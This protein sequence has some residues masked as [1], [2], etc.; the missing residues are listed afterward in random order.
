MGNLLP[1][2]VRITPQRTDTPPNNVSPTFRPNVK[3]RLP[4]TASLL[5]QTDKENLLVQCLSIIRRMIATGALSRKIPEPA[6]LAKNISEFA[7]RH[8]FNRVDDIVLQSN[9]FWVVQRANRVGVTGDDKRLTIPLQDT[10][11]SS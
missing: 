1:T 9:E 10:L 8:G 11:R 2:T 5:K 7:I 3:D 4:N 6:V